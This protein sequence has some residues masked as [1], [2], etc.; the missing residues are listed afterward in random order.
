M[1]K[2]HAVTR[3]QVEGCRSIRLDARL[4]PDRRGAEDPTLWSLRDF[5]NLW[6]AGW[7][8]HNES[9]RLAC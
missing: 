6:I 8:M 2:A 5:D 1:K 4:A 9:R 3:H 7:V